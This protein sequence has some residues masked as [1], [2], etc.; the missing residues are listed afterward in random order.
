MIPIRPDVVPPKSYE[1]LDIKDVKV[2]HHPAGAPEPTPIIIVSLDRPTRRNAYTIEMMEA[3]ELVYPMLDVDERVRAVILTGS[4][5]AFCA[6][7]DFSKGPP[8]Q[9][10]RNMDHRDSGG[11][12]NLAIYRCRKPTICAING[13]AVGIG[14]T[15]TLSSAIRISW[16]GAKCGLPFVRRG[17]TMESNSSFFLPRLI[18]Y[19]NATYLVVTGEVF[20]A[21][22]NLFAGL[23]QELVDKQEDVLPRAL[24]LA[25]TLVNQTSLLASYLNRE[26]IWHNPGSAEATHLVDSPTLYHMFNSQD[27]QEG[28][29]SFM[30]KRGPSFK[31]SVER[32]LPPYF[33]WW[34][35]SDVGRRAR[36][37]LQKL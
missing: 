19:S 22:S 3:F 7:L 8:D 27:C 10:E 33:P 24:A 12:I 36:G 25:E 1:T 4:G 5:T 16:V 34:M 11:R 26:L 21:N 18:G 32:G 13:P 35:P 30:E 31:D 6:G 29:E 2:S 14:L 15:M 37:Q 28:F 20:P 9:D 23:F 17:I